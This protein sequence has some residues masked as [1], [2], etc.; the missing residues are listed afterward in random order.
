MCV[1]VC[2]WVCEYSTCGTELTVGPAEGVKGETYA[3]EEKKEEEGDRRL[4]SYMCMF[5]HVCVC[6]CVQSSLCY[7]T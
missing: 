1:S 4:L 5:M 7:V 3:G 6:V 2:E